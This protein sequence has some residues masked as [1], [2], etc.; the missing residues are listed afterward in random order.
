MRSNICL[1]P[2]IKCTELRQYLKLKA[3]TLLR[4][5]HISKGAKI[6]LYKISRVKTKWKEGKKCC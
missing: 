3:E 4:A 5:P 6:F 1:K 2:K